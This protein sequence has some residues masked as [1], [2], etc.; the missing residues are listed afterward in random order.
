MTPVVFPDVGYT[1]ANLR[2]LLRRTNTTQQRAAAM[3]GVNER[4][5]N[6]WCAPIDRA[7]HTDM[8]SKKWVE[9]QKILTPD[10]IHEKISRTITPIEQQ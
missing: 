2:L 7:Q 9:L 5:V 3:L 8:P 1:P 6:S 10:L 4:T